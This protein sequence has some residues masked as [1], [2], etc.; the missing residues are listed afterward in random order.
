MQLEACLSWMALWPNT[1]HDLHAPLT[2]CSVHFFST[3]S[4]LGQTQDAAHLTVVVKEQDRSPCDCVFYFSLLINCVVEEQMFLDMPV[5]LVSL[6][7]CIMRYYYTVLH[8]YMCQPHTTTLQLHPL[9]PGDCWLIMGSACRNYVIVTCLGW[10]SPLDGTVP[11]LKAYR[12]TSECLG[13]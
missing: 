5:E 6:S 2:S 1:L 7:C 8:N 12:Q 11:E 3:L 9:T 13:L 10:R 4:I